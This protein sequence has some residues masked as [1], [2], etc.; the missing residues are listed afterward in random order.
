M[1]QHGARSL[2]YVAGLVGLALF[3]ALIGYQGV[4]DVA[5][6]VASA[7]AG[8][9]VITIFHLTT[10]VAH[11]IAWQRLLP[12]SPP[13]RIRTL[14]WARWIAE[15]INDLLPVVQIGGN[16]VRAVLISRA[17]VPGTAAGGSVVVD[18]TTNFV[19]QLLF[20][21]IG[22]CVLLLG[23]RSGAPTA[24]VSLGI[25]IMGLTV[26]AFVIAQRQGMFGFLARRIERL[27]WSPEWRTLTPS[28]ETM[29]TVVRD[30]YRDRRAI[31]A[32]T[33]WHL[34]SW[35]AGAVEIW[36]ALSFLHHPLSLLAV[37]LLEALTEAV[38]TAAF[39]VPGALG[40]Q[41][42][43][44]VLAGAWLG[45]PADVALA[46]SLAKRVREVLLGVPGLVVWQLHGTASVLGKRGGMKGEG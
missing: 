18:V 14:L 31:T 38:R 9:A 33:A 27:A 44:Y 10:L 1:P 16:L 4:G 29:D 3:T 11:S 21:V 13:I 15:S 32:A 5:A 45:L 26:V 22:L 23:F 17:G 25:V 24:S 34:I 30:L 6:I 8:I 37:V 35:L 28:A 41:E 43:G 7:G 2:T 39:A 12:A 46:V 42:G 36:I 20:T 19:A 40:V